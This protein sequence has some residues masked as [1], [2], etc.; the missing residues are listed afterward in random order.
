M[1]AERQTPSSSQGHR[2][3]LR[4]CLL[5]AAAVVLLQAYIPLTYEQYFDSD[6]AVYGLMAKHLSEGRAFPLF[7]Y[8][9]NYLLGVQSWLAVPAFWIGGPTVAMLRTPLVLLNL[10]VALGYTWTLARLGLRPALA[11]AA[12]LPVI[13]F[14][15]VKAMEFAAAYGAGIEPF[16]YVLLLWWLRGRPLVF[17]ALLG[18]GTLHREF[19][20]LALPA[21]AV[22]LWPARAER[23]RE[24]LLRLASGFAAIWL[25]VDVIKRQVNIYGP[26]GGAWETGSVTLGAQTFAQWLSFDVLAYLARTWTLVRSGVPD[27][28][29]VSTYS[30]RTYSFPSDLSAGS[31]IAGALLAVAVIVAAARLLWIRGHEPARPAGDGGRFTVYLAAL[32]VLNLLIYGINGGIDPSDAAILRYALFAPLLIVSLSAQYFLR[33][34]SRTW[35]TIVG[36]CLTLWAAGSV[37]DNGRLI[38]QMRTDPPPRS[39]RV[40]ANY[41][42]NH[43]IRYAR[44]NYWDA[45]VITFLSGERVVVASTGTVRISAYQAVVDDRAETAVTLVR[46]PCSEGVAVAAWCVVAPAA[47]VRP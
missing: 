11:L 31:S 1:S 8:G 15:P 25:V 12:A 35:A 14:T 9:Q 4:A 46:Q 13:A 18:F 26:A 24:F 27:M 10:S 32:A 42:M 37:I 29:G 33:E 19:T 43:G 3:E 38:A 36:V 22:A 20:F 47:S 30:L 21:L 28:L 44:A 2:L 7:F 23:R 39:H 45:Y 40:M 16:L 17:G 34:R 41:L 6:Q 5:F